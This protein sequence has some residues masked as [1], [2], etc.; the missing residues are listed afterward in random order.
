MTDV[1]TKGRQAYRKAKDRARSRSA[2]IT[3]AGQDI[4]PLPAVADVVRREMAAQSF[5]FFCETYF[6]HLFSLAWS[7]DHLRVL[8]KIERVVNN[9]ETL[10]VA[11]PRGSG[12]TTLCMIAVIWA[13]LTGKHKFVFLVG[14]AQDSA[15]ASLANIKSHLMS[16]DLLLADFPEA[17]YPIRLL[18][19]EARRCVGQKYYG[20]PTNVVWGTE[21]VVMPMIPGSRSSGSIIRVAGITGNIRGALHVRPDGSQI[22]PSLVICDDPQTDSSAHSLVQTE[23]RLRI[24]NGAI[25]GLAGPG[26]RTAIIIPCTVIQSGD[27]ADQLLDRQKNP[28]WHGERTRLMISMPLNDR[29][30][31]EYAHIRD[32]S[33]RN[34][35][36]GHEATE[37]YIKHRKAMDAGAEASWPARYLQ[38]LGKISAIQHGMNIKFDNE[39]AFFA[40]YQNDPIQPQLGSENLT[41]DRLED[42]VRSIKKG[43]VPSWCNMLTAGVDVHDDILYWMVVAW[44]K[45]SFAGHVVDY[46]VWPDQ[47][48]R[49]F[50]QGAIKKTL[51]RQYPGRGKESAIRKGLDH[52]IAELLE[53]KYPGQD[54]GLN[55]VGKIFVDS[56]YLPEIIFQAIA[57]S[58]PR[59][60]QPSRGFPIGAKGRPFGENK[61][62]RN[63]REVLGDS[64]RETTPP[65]Y[66]ALR[67]VFLE[68]NYWKTFVRARLTTALGD[69]GALSICKTRGNAL[70]FEHL[71]SE[72]GQVVEAGGRKVVEWA[73]KVNQD[74]HWWD[75][76]V[77]AAAAASVAGCRIEGVTGGGRKKKRGRK[78]ISEM[79]KGRIKW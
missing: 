58:D 70:L 69:L 34:D 41:L 6:P 63:R 4:A 26:L 27:L 36:D 45:N 48:I 53:A 39:E 51:C 8:A 33:L 29:K 55:L 40:E 76:L 42:A 17:I 25:R 60:V 67:Q 23:E 71:S 61:S 35:G 7:E 12:K 54:G 44:D 49:Y 13:I 11:M 75:T 21:F 47:R 62:K 20:V 18:E 37:F 19:G 73:N 77:Y 65:K 74:N 24:V 2:Q 64:W 15:L 31:A 28:V 50:R 78:S 52:V 43:V 22:R 5:R 30:W 68:T 32:E 9:Y 1:K 3:L 10:A 16:N 72:Y 56:G 66:R 57:E 79:Q 38:E 14:P 46:G 59:T